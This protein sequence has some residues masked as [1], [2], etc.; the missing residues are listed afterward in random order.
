MSLNFETLT[1]FTYRGLAPHKFTPL[2]GVHKGNPPDRYA[3]GDFFVNLRVLMMTIIEILF[4]KLA[5]TTWDAIE[6]AFVNRISFGEDAITSINLLALKNASFRNLAIVDTRPD[7]STKGCD[8]EF[9]IG[10][11]NSGWLRYAIQAKKISVSS[12][13][14]D[15]LSHFVGNIPQIDVLETYSRANGAIP[16]YCLYNF[17][18]HSSAISSS[19]PKFRHAKE[20]GCS[21]TPSS[22]VKIALSKWGAKNFTW[23][24][25]RPET[26][27]WSCLVRCPQINQHWPEK[28]IGIRY[29]EALRERL[30]DALSSLLHG[31][32]ISEH[33]EDLNIFSQEIPYRPKWVGVININEDNDG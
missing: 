21:V 26:L 30:P 10:R 2:P 12:G 24:H 16:L 33:V 14:Y 19:C 17:S 3:P 4:E 6:N 9:W 23:F 15:S 5:I 13:R 31:E 1:G 29:A 18:N 8:F 7:E 22:T 27:P 32:S 28:V 20:Y 11:N 25:A